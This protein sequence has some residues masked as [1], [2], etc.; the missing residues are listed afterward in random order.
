MYDCSVRHVS[1]AYNFTGKERDSESGLDNFEARYFGSSL[2]RFMSPDPSIALLLRI[3]N[4]QRWNQYSYAIDNPLSYV[5]PTGRDAAAVNFSGMVGGFGH[6]GILAI[7]KDGTATYARFGPKDHSAG[8]LGGARAPGVV[9]ACL[10]HIVVINVAHHADA[11]WQRAAIHSRF[12]YGVPGLSLQLLR[13]YVEAPRRTSLRGPS[14]E[15]N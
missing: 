2:G 13:Q 15:K 8:N 7:S 3:I 12:R 4:P 1:C 5:D 10:A 6:E 11:A 9:E 14:C